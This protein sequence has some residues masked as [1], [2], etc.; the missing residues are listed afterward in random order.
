[1]GE[2]AF[3]ILERQ[4]LNRRVPERES[5][6]REVQAWAAARTEVRATVEW[7]FSPSEAREKFQRHSPTVEG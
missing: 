2:I 7:R 1:M 5:V 3:S 4:C 6:A